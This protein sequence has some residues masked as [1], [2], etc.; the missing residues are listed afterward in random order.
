MK[1][2]PI[3]H[4]RNQRAQQR[5]KGIAVEKIPLSEKFICSRE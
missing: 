5:V 1:E 3:G 2:T 4:E